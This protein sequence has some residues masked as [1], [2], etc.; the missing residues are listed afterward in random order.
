VNLRKIRIRT[1]INKT[2][3]KFSLQNNGE[4]IDKLSQKNLKKCKSYIIAYLS[5]NALTLKF[6]V[7]MMLKV[8]DVM[9]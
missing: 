5:I 3:V 7:V 2:S 8:L 9:L 4:N 1:K 6:N